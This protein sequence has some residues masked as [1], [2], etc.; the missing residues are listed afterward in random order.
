MLNPDETLR[1]LKWTEISI[2]SIR[3]R[4]LGFRYFNVSNVIATTIVSGQAYDIRGFIID[5]AFLVTK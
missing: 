3:Y 4:L 1:R 2:V 5:S